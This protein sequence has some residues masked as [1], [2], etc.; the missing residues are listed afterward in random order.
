MMTQNFK[1]NIFLYNKNK[2]LITYVELMPCST[3]GLATYYNLKDRTLTKVS[4][5]VLKERNKTYTDT[6]K[7][8]VVFGEDCKLFHMFF[9]SDESYCKVIK[10]DSLR[11]DPAQVLT[12]IYSHNE[13]CLEGY[14]INQSLIQDWAKKL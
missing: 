8:I 10:K 3:D 2:E 13:D 14:T 1:K 7:A 11:I 9:D 12:T 5:D 4:V 6:T